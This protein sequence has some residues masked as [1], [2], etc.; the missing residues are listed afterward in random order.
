[1]QF[2]T[3]L[4][5]LFCRF[6]NSK[7]H[8]IAHFYFINCIKSRS[9]RTL[10]C[11]KKMFQRIDTRNIFALFR[12]FGANL[13]GHLAHTLCRCKGSV[14]FDMCK[15]LCWEKLG[16]ITNSQTICSWPQGARILRSSYFRVTSFVSLF[17]FSSLV[18]C[19]LK[20]VIIIRI[21]YI[22]IQTM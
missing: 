3:I 16:N 5:V 8:K 11:I 19:L 22:I 15:I 7:L 9:R 14:F 4:T 6:Y 21:C 20:G 13:F 12:S 10:N 1:M 17:D 18:L 2:S